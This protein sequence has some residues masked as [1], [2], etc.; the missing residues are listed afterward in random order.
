[1]SKINLLY[2]TGN[3]LIGGAQE[4]VK[5]L[6]INLDRRRFEVAVYSLVDYPEKTDNELLT[7]EIKQDGF[8][9]VT[10]P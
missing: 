10:V 4:L 8:L 5:T 3:L 7:R 1:M 2:V 6:V 9:L